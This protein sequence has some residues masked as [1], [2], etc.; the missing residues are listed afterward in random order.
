MQ[1]GGV[2]LNAEH[3]RLLREAGLRPLSPTW[4]KLEILIGLAAAAI[5]LLCGMRGVQD[6][7]AAEAWPLIAAS[8]LL[9]TLG[10]YLALAGHRSHLYQSQNKLAAYLAALLRQNAGEP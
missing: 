2:D 1:E 10:G 9:Q 4:A 6:L 7:A 8:V 3:E 5:G